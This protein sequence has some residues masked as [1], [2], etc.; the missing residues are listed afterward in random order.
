VRHPDE[1]VQ[2]WNP[3]EGNQFFWF[4]DAFGTTQYQHELSDDWN[5]TFP[6]IAAALARGA[7]LL[8]T[9]RTYI[10]ASAMRDLKYEAL[11]VIRESQVV[12]HV[13]EL[14][15]AE[16]AQILYNHIKLGGQPT[17]FKQS[18]RPCLPKVAANRNFLPETA[19][20]LGNPL[21]TKGLA[22][23]AKSVDSFVS[24]PV[25]M[26][27]DIIRTLDSGSRA[28]LCLIFMVGGRLA[29]PLE[30]SEEQKRAMVRLGAK[31]AGIVDALTALSGSLTKFVTADGLNS[32]IYQHPTVRDAVATYVAA[33]PELIDVYLAGTP[34]DKIVTEV[35]CGGVFVEGASVSVPANRYDTIIA[36]LQEL[37]LH[38]RC[39]FLTNRCER[40]F[41]EKY[42][43]V[44]DTVLQWPPSSEPV[45]GGF[46]F[47]DLAF[48]KRLNQLGLLNGH[49]REGFVGF[50]WE[51]ATEDAN[52]DL[53]ADV[54]LRSILTSSEVQGLSE[55]IRDE[56]LENVDR[57][58]E[59]REEDW[60]NTKEPDDP[61]EHFGGLLASLEFAD[62]LAS[63]E[64]SQKTIKRARRTIDSKIE[65]MRER[66][67]PEGE[68]D[69]DDIGGA[70]VTSGGDDIF[71]D[72][73]E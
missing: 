20:R 17:S 67:Y 7:K 9:S 34:I 38:R 11:P 29:S 8:M 33:N 43:A 24:H 5:R 47:Y 21:F 53:V 46:A 18:I 3:N 25:G 22:L 58:I 35:V 66:W 69:Y 28:A 16:K 65:E 50:V 57:W 73:A 70:S 1:F 2:H 61:E 68:P 37:S 55:F 19:R 56:F 15:G 64:V 4:D 51:R 71:S 26:L 52:F 23:D 10:F 41:I 63:D 40:G 49:L 45:E 14:T 31:T 42:I 32:W 59:S 27:L 13:S 39:T 6:H 44:D 54:E 72:V 60:D 12:I 36:N 48:V 62:F 30:L